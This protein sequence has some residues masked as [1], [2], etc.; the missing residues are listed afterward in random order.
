V[1]RVQVELAALLHS[2][3]GG[4]PRV[5]ARGATLA[6]VL[7]DLDRRYPGL[8][9]RVVDEQDRLRPH[10]R[11]F[12]NGSDTRDIGTPLAE[13]DRVFIVGALSGGA[14]AAGRMRFLLLMCRDEAA[15]EA[16]SLEERQAIYRDAVAY[17]EQLRA[18]GR[19]EG[20]HPLEPSRTAVTV[21]LREGRPVTTD[22]PFVE[23]KEQLGGYSVV[24]ADSLEEALEIARRHPLLRAHS[25]EVRPIRDGPPR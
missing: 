8:R 9:F 14:G 11:F 25:I 16:L 5:E 12:V 23:T 2:Y 3:T 4:A 15:W 7:A 1:S 21:R 18:R 6:E 17:S 20:G 13:G 10:V 24:T 22:G 19:Y